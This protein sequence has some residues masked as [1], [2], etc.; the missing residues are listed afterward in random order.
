MFIGIRLNFRA[1]DIQ[2]NQACV[3]F[4]DNIRCNCLESLLHIL[5][6]FFVDGIAEGFFCRSFMIRLVQIFTLHLSSSPLKDMYPLSTKA[7]K[8]V[9]HILI[10]S[11]PFLLTNAALFLRYF[12]VSISSMIRSKVIIES[13]ILK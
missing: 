11:Y 12:A 3:F 7:S 2:L 9:C 10:V 4:W 13:I 8:I 5:D 6:K 1:V